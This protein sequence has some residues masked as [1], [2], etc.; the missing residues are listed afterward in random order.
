MNDELKKIYNNS[1]DIWGYPQIY[2]SIEFCPIKIKDVSTL[3]LF[4]KIFQYPKNYISEKEIVKSSYLKYL[5]YFIQYSINPNGK[6]IENWLI[7]LLKYI[8]KQEKIFFQRKLLDIPIDNVLNKTIITLIINNVE[9]NEQ[10]FDIIRAI[11]LEQNGL[12]VEYIEEYRPDLEKNLLFLNNK[13]NDVTFEDEIFVFCSLMKKTIN[14]IK[15][16]T[17][18]QFKK[19]FERLLVTFNFELY[20]PLEVSGQIQPK[21]KGEEIIKHYLSH[22]GKK[23]RYNDILVSK[24]EFVKNSSIFSNEKSMHADKEGNVYNVPIT[25]GKI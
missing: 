15:D 12:N 24:D 19:H 23:E 14:E 25:E 9:F 17:M 13:F 10:E 16:Y 5:L 4:Y 20:S 1:N 7:E 2:K 21:Q 3:D 11:I 8:T 6:E 22:F 18:Y